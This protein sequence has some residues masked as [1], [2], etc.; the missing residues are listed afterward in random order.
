MESGEATAQTGIV[1]DVRTEGADVIVVIESKDA[2]GSPRTS[3]AKFCNERPQEQTEALSAMQLKMRFDLAQEAKKT[4]SKM[5]FGTRGIWNG[6]LS[7]L[8]PLA[9]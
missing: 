7:F 2:F 8:R 9:G 4:K 5:V 1:K 3:T 6:C